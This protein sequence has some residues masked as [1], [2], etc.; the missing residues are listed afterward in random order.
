MPL[1]CTSYLLLILFDFCFRLK[2][3]SKTKNKVDEKPLE[4]QD[5]NAV[6]KNL[7]FLDDDLTLP[8]SRKRCGSTPFIVNPSP[9]KKKKD[10]QNLIPP[11]KFLLGGNISDPLNLNSLQNEDISK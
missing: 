2:M 1:P 11:K 7:Q 9:K 3:A 8:L 6:S 10:G 5:L 4:T